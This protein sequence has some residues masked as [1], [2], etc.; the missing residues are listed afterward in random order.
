MREAKLG[1]NNPMYLKTKSPEFLAM[2]TR[3]KSG[4]RNP[5][6]EKPK[7]EETLQ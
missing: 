4:C 6:Y 1:E 5:M 7:S 2:Q 3:D